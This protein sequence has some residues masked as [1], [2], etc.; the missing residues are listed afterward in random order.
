MR[1]AVLVDPRSRGFQYGMLRDFQDEVLRITGGYAVETPHRELPR[2]IKSRIGHGMRYG[3]FRKLI[4]KAEHDIRADVL[5]VVLMGPE[6][7]TL[8]MYK[9][10]D[11][12]VGLKILYLFDT[13]EKQLPSVR[14]VL[15][16]T[17]WDLVITS[18]SGAQGF[19]QEHTQR[20]WHVIPQGVKLDRFAPP[21]PEEKII[22]FCSYGR[23]LE[24][25]HEALRKY[26]SAARC[27]YE[28]TTAATLQPHL[29]PRENYA[30]YGWHLAHSIFNVCWP[31]E[32][33][34]PDRV[35]TF[36]PITCRWFEAA[37][38]GNVVIGRAPQDPGVEELFGSDFV[39]PVDHRATPVEFSAL[40][41]DLWA[42]RHHHIEQA[43]ARRRA[44]ADRW[45]WEARVLSILH[46]LKA[47]V[48]KPQERKPC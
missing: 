34:H 26:S 38:S 47:D 41:E 16:D 9:G 10:W 14:R 42:H 37:A 33:T 11:T 23:R 32:V 40:L 21:A 15:R 45:S 18:F 39:I 12:H 29:D 17:H 43:S 24:N 46:L 7:Y 35:F 28:Y 25:L 1:H 20:E 3:D 31:V 30:M 48:G 4:P 6:D 44:F 27:H 8:D 22:G 5:W 19:L 2:F 13:M 36:S